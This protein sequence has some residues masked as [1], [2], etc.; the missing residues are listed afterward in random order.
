MLHISFIKAKC[1]GYAEEEELIL[2]L[3]RRIWNDTV[4][5]NVLEEGRCR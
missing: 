3:Q 5:K 1:I 2:D 4:Q